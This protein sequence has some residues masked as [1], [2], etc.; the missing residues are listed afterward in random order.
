MLHSNYV[1]LKWFMITLL[2]SI[3]LVGVYAKRG[4]R[5]W[6]RM[7]AE[8]ERIATEIAA[9]KTEKE[10]LERRIAA[11]KSNRQAQELLVRQML[12]FVREEE[13]VIEFGP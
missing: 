11:I 5:D 6:R 12:G 4:L 2:I 9:Q 10:S 7:T 3:T 13:W 8:N 1:V